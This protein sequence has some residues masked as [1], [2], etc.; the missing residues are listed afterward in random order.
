MKPLTD[1]TS[2]QANIARH[3]LS[4]L[5]AALLIL[6]LWSRSSRSRK[7]LFRKKKRSLR[8]SRRSSPG[9]KNSLPCWKNTC[10]L[11]E[12]ACMAE[13]QKKATPRRI[14]SMKPNS[15]GV[16]TMKKKQLLLNPRKNARSLRGASHSHLHCPAIRSVLS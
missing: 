16:V 2:L 6:T 11:N 10:V 4:R 15:P 12:R 8:N 5:L 14:S 9:S 7:V 13:A 3:Y 1:T